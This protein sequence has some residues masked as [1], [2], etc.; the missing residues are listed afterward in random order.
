MI[1]HKLRP[2]LLTPYT[3]LRFGQYQHPTELTLGRVLGRG[4]FCVVNEITKVVLK[5]ETANSASNEKSDDEH[6]IQNIVQDRGFMASHYIRKGKDY[7]YAIKKMQE[8]S[9]KDHH[10]FI[11]SIVDLAVEARFLSVVRHP[12]IIKMRAMEATNPCSP[13][14]FVLL[15]RLYDI[16]PTRLAAWKKRKPKGLGKMM[17]DRRGLKEQAFWVERLTVAYDLSCALNYLHG[18]K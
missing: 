3:S 9:R 5:K 11:N 15:D 2:D 16:M 12:N 7:R 8:A 18:L 14:F 10:V 6:Y 4:G 13:N 17:F 1:Y